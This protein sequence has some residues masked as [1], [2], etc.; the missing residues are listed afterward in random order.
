MKRTG[1][2]FRLKVTLLFLAAI[3][4]ATAQAFADDDWE[5]VPSSPPAEVSAP[6]APGSPP[7]QAARHRATRNAPAAAGGS[8]VMIA[9]GERAVPPSA[10]IQAIVTQINGAWGSNIHVYQ[11]V[12]PEG[13]HAMA[14]GCIFYNPAALAMLLGLRLDL[15]DPNVMTPM[16]YAI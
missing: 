11:S 13:P 6:V 3:G 8:N 14:G 5:A 9:C 12:A 16:L 2:T 7:S 15:T 4:L 10:K 1:H